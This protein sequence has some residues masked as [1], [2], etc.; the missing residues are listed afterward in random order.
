[1]KVSG[2]LHAPTVLTRERARG[3]HWTEGWVRPRSGLDAAA[4]RKKSH[5]C[6]CQEF[7]AIIKRFRTQTLHWLHNV[8]RT[9]SALGHYCMEGK[10]GRRDRKKDTYMYKVSVSQSV[11]QS[12]LQACTNSGSK[13]S[14]QTPDS[15]AREPTDTRFLFLLGDPTWPSGIV[16][17]NYKSAIN[18]R[19]TQAFLI[20]GCCVG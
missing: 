3:T 10:D 2:Q 16:R 19:N 12:A 18:F 9:H 20:T 6:P 4:K 8:Q 1:M 15:E 17:T 13:Q 5:L 14:D 7:G 11:S